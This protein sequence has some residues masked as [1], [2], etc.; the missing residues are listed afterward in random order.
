MESVA[1]PNESRRT[2]EPHHPEQLF[3]PQL[4]LT[5]IL[6]H[7]PYD[8]ASRSREPLE[9]SLQPRS[10]QQTLSAQ[11][12]YASVKPS[13][14][15]DALYCAA[16]ALAAVMSLRDDRMNK[17]RHAKLMFK[18][19]HSMLIKHIGNG[20]RKNGGDSGGKDHRNSRR[21]TNRTKATPMPASKY[22]CPL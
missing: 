1:H 21:V 3:Q 13:P 18:T 5:G 12:L 11:N 22:L 16:A 20:K 4:P 14:G 17:Q 2:S 19:R 7:A 9:Q 10:V 6:A 15:P 8:W